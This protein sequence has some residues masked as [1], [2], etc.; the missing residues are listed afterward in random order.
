ME[1]SEKELYETFNKSYKETKQLLDAGYAILEL[2]GAADDKKFLRQVYVD[3][4][5][6]VKQIDATIDWASENNHI[7]IWEGALELKEL[8][9]DLLEQVGDRYLLIGDR[10]DGGGNETEETIQN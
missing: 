7:T 3:W 6:Q 10:D 2:E 1:H 8:I 9:M 5:G 4:A